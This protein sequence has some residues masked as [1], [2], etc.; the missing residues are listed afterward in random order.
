MSRVRSRMRTAVAAVVLGLAAAA[1]AGGP[2]GYGYGYGPPPLVSTAFNAEHFAWSQQ[3]GRGAI[4]GLVNYRQGARTYACTGSVAL[5][6][7]T[8][9]T[10]ER[11]RIL[12]GGVDRAAVPEAVVRA[13]TVPDPAADY[14][15]FVRSATC[16]NGRFTFDG[17]PDGGWFVITP[18][19]ANGSERVVLMQYVRTRGQRVPVTL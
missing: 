15:G 7:E 8:P 17:L 12:Y 1:C 4:D 14:R 19:A 16:Q 18:V 13:R 6:P 3:P 5:T 2:G 9:Y 10:R 11:F